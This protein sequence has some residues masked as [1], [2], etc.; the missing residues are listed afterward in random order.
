MVFVKGKSG[1]PNGRPPAGF[2]WAETLRE[3]GEEIEP[4]TGKKYRELVSRRIWL[5]CVN[6]NVGAIKEL[7]NRMEG[8]PRAVSDVNLTGKLSIADLV[9][10]VTE[11]APDGSKEE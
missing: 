1:N 4:T 8:L 2:S 6:G 9:R 7:F 5:E 10:E 3:V 11:D